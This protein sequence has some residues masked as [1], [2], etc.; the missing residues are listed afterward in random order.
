MAAAEI[1]KSRFGRWSADSGLKLS[2][3]FE[4]RDAFLMPRQ[5]REIEMN[6]REMKL[7]GIRVVTNGRLLFVCF[8]IF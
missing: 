5:K 1:L 4:A 3:N 7:N 2:H 6:L 8:P